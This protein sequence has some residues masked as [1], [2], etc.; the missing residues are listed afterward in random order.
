MM[1]NIEEMKE[2]V[3]VCIN[4]QKLI[5][6]NKRKKE[7]DELNHFYDLIRHQKN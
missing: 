4:I 1:T 6:K 7:E 3:S 5:A 2:I